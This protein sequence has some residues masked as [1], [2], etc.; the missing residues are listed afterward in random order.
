[1]AFVVEDGTGLSTSNS[2]QSVA[3]ADA[4]FADRG[5]VVWVA[6]TNAQKQAALVRATSYVDAVFRFIGARGDTEQ[7]LQWPRVSA[8]DEDGYVIE[9]IPTCLKSACSEYALRSASAELAPDLEYAASGT[10]TME[11][12][13]V[14]PV[15]EE[16]RYSGVSATAIRQ[17]PLADALISA[18]TLPKGTVFRG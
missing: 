17:Y 11:K 18:I 3:G 16:K 14:G 1:M 6:L 13:I 15:T 7:A 2:Y 12:T 10:L 5:D 4:Y 8:Y 9:G